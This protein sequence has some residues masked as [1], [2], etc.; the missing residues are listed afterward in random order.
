[1]LSQAL[2]VKHATTVG[3]NTLINRNGAQVGFLTT[4]GFE[5]TT[6]IMRAI[7]VNGCMVFSLGLI[8]VQMK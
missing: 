3:T 7:G 5:D 6:L 2:V 8:M 4:K 1:M